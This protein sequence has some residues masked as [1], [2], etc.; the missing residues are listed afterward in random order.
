[1]R[2]GVDASWQRFDTMVLAGSPLRFFRL[3]PGG[4]RVVERIEAAQEVGAST[5]TD[6]LSDAGAVH[7]VRVDDVPP[8]FRVDD[9]TVVTPQLDGVAHDDG[10]ITV[11]DGSV[12]PIPGAQLRLEP[13]QGPASARNAARPLVETP[14]VAFLDADV[15]TPNPN[16]VAELL[17]HFDD[18]RVGLVAPRVR[19]EM[20][21]PLDLG[22]QPARVRA[23]TRVSYVPGAALLVR[24]DAID[25]IGGFDELLRFGEDVDLVWRLD[26]AGWHCRY[27]PSV[28]VW[29]EPRNSWRARMRQHAGY[30]TSAA[31]LAMRHPG[32]L[33]PIH[34][35]GWTAATWSL[36]LLGRV[37]AAVALGAGS[38]AALVRK[39]RDLPP[40]AS[41]TLAIRGHLLAG[42]QFADAARRVWWPILAI[43]AVVSRRGRW[44]AVVALLSDPRRAPTDLAYGWG[45][46]TG[47]R[48]TRTLAPIVP[49]LSAWPGRQPRRV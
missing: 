24:V 43:I 20:L 36:A 18:P 30:G 35:N 26:Q 34:V 48:R 12:P 49:R 44:W 40:R 47:M 39:L 2:F 16:W 31:P 7:P 33:S 38:S 21:S 4:V 19:G 32:A 25:A 15:S 42:R 11:D 28:S 5:L 8:R 6:R 10:R 37:P 22:E 17:W 3:T 23:G 13:N 45:V 46:W 1:M 27:E 29:H 9:V 14:L 41:L